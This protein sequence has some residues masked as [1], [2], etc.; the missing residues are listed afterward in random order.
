MYIAITEM[1]EVE[2]ISIKVEPSYLNQWTNSPDESF[3]GGFGFEEEDEEDFVIVPSITTASGNVD[4][5]DSESGDWKPKMK[6]ERNSP[7]EEV[8]L[9]GFVIENRGTAGRK[10]SSLSNR[11]CPVCKRVFER[12]SVVNRHWNITHVGKG[13][14]TCPTCQEVFTRKDTFYDHKKRHRDPSIIAITL[15]KPDRSMFL[16]ESSSLSN[17]RIENE[18]LVGNFSRAPGK[19][20][21]DIDSSVQEISRE[22]ESTTQRTSGRGRKKSSLSTRTCPTC[23]R[24]FE[25]PSLMNRHWHA[26]HIGEGPYN[27]PASSCEAV[28]TRK[29]MFFEHKRQHNDPSLLEIP[30]NAQKLDRECYEDEQDYSHSSVCPKD[31]VSEDEDYSPAQASEQDDSDS[32]YEI[33]PSKRSTKKTSSRKNK[34]HVMWRRHTHKCPICKLRCFGHSA[35]IRHI[36]IRHQESGPFTCP[37]CNEVTNRKDHFFHHKNALHPT[38]VIQ[39][40]DEICRKHGVYLS[41][42]LT[43]LSG[44]K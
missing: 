31:N 43:T 40:A 4:K 11:T 27:C 25:R 1:P 2:T 37:E 17:S 33:R 6:G 32:D 35:V 34:K 38:L 21:F 29:D 36:H 24:I 44:N 19:R 15:D 8:S 9:P 30:E 23:K 3:I 13:P 26:K 39:E 12:P 22:P 41:S 20:S 18:Q 42:D 7:V 28:F 10:K 14:Y 16:D 5:D